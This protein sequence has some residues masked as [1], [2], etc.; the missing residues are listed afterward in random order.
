MRKIGRSATSLLYAVIMVVSAAIVIPL[1]EAP[2][3]EVDVSVSPAAIYVAGTG[4]PDIATV[5]LTVTGDGDAIAQNFPVDVMLV[6]DTSWSM[7]W[8][9][10]DKKIRDAKKAACI[11]VDQLGENDQSG[12]VSFGSR[13]YLNQSL[14]FDHNKTKAEINGLTTYGQTAMGDGIRLARL[15]IGDNGR[16]DSI[17]VMILL[18]DGR[19]NLGVD[20]IKEA[21][22]AKAA[23]IV[24]Y[25][26]GLGP[27]ADE[28]TLMEIATDE[29][30]YYFTPDS[31]DLIAIYSDISERIANIAGIDIVV[32]HVLND[33]LDYVPFSFSMPGTTNG[34]TITWNVS[35]LNI[36]DVWSVTFDIVAS[37]CGQI[38]VN[39]YP[40]SGVEYTMYDGLTGTTPFPETFIE[41]LCPQLV[42]FTWSPQTPYEGQIVN[43]TD[44]SVSPHGTVVISW[45]WDFGDGFPHSDL[46]NP[47][48][49]YADNGPFNVTLTVT[50]DDGGRGEAT[51]IVIVLNV[52]PTVELKALPLNVGVS[53]RIAGEKWHDVSIE[54]LEDGAIVAEGSLTRYPGSPN[55]QM[56]DL[57]TLQA[58]I[59]REYSTIVRYTP[60][61]DSVNGQLNGANPCWL[62]LGFGSQEEVRLHHTFNVQHSDSYV[63]EVDI[64]N[65]ILS[66]GLSFVGSAWDPGADDLTFHWDFGDGTTLTSLYPNLDENFP[67]EVS[68]TVTHS[69]SGSGTFTVTLI[70][71]DDDGGTNTAIVIVVIP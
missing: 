15:E 8:M 26:I 4:T 55:N 71:E 24:I 69:F 40:D 49:V 10:I 32:T 38:P 54:L 65:E 47:T 22:K 35:S 5:T 12:L 52:P 33:G 44:L 56:L 67:V 62:I 46:Q 28:D 6:I 63:W 17:H 23:G 59:S 42:D 16:Q 29:N 9:G 13:A 31:D 21:T 7:G 51:V 1:H 36:G 45:D 18:S 39:I 3:L 61:D 58:D 68:E 34:K 11:F 43:F 19:K 70:V 64:T 37:G 50:Y 30:H 2:H 41:V 57:T 20:P 60:E 48:H 25:S 66:H 53:L 27:D 14:T